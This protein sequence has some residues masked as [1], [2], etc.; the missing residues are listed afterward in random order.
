MPAQLLFDCITMC[1]YIETDTQTKN[2]IDNDYDLAVGT[3]LKEKCLKL[4][5][6]VFEHLKVEKDQI[7]Q[8]TENIL[9]GKLK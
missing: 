2:N 3:Q 6:Q 7:Y 1:A 4:S 5:H 8:T 9:V